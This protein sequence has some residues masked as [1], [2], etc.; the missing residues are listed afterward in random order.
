[1]KKFSPMKNIKTRQTSVEAA[2]LE[3]Q[4]G[5]K[6]RKKEAKLLK[7]SRVAAKMHKLREVSEH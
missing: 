1:M 5:N 2:N 4:N 3:K 6:A 7:K